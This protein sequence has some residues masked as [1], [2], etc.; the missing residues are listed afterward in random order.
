MEI[1]KTVAMDKGQEANK[2]MSVKEYLV[3]IVKRG[4]QIF[5]VNPQGWHPGG[6]FPSIQSNWLADTYIDGEH[7]MHRVSKGA[8]EQILNLAYNKSDN[9]IEHKEVPDRKKEIAGGS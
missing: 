1:L 8:P 2:G 4:Q 5:E 7:N 6:P 3:E 9:D